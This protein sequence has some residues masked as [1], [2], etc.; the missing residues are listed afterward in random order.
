[1]KISRFV[2][3]TI[4]SLELMIGKSPHSNHGCWIPLLGATDF[5]SVDLTEIRR[6]LAKS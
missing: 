3:V 6:L 5:G 2:I 1:M 4:R